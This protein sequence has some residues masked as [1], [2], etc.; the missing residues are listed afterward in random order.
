MDESTHVGA[1]DRSKFGL[2]LTFYQRDPAYALGLATISGYA[3]QA[4]RDVRVHLVPI[5]RGDSVEKI[6]D[7]VSALEPDLVGVSAMAPTWLPLDDHLRALKRARPAVPICVGGYQG[8]VSPE[9]TIA[10]PAVDAVCVGDGEQPVVDLILRLRGER[11]PADPIAGLWEK[12]PDG[13]TRRTA[14]WLVRELATFPFPDYTIFERAGDV[15]YLSPHAVES[16]RLTTLPVLSGRGCPYRCSYCANTTLLDL[17]GGRGG[18]LRKHDAAAL[19]GELVRLRVR[20]SVDFFQFWDEEFLYDHR[21]AR[22]LL[23]GYRDAVAVPF[24]MFVRPESM[25]DELCAVAADAGCHSMWFGVESGSE[26]YRRRY[27]NRRMPNTQLVGA[28]EAAR[29]HG[30]KCM[31]FG[32]VGLPFESR[33]DARGTL[34]L[35]RALAPELAIV[36]QFVPLPGTPLHALCR[37]HDLL[38][39]P[40]VDQQMWPLGTLNVRPHPGGMSADEMRDAGEEIM[41]YLAAHTRVDI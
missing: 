27:L 3:K 6:V 7:L 38:L 10:H 12:M 31:A 22:Q 5:F 34:D 21:Y 14:P 28:V 36:S 17:Y 19:V 33:S 23:A 16:K 15:R 41:A 30:I 32:M 2:V 29:R 1:A 35:L 13:G 25:T 11:S 24:S 4:L 8:I 40:S 9:E 26:E 37:E 20:Y 39:P 18:L